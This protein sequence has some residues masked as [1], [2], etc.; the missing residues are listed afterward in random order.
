MIFFVSLFFYKTFF[1]SFLFLQL[2]PHPQIR[3]C[4]QPTSAAPK[5][6]QKCPTMKTELKKCPQKM[7]TERKICPKI[8]RATPARTQVL[9]LEVLRKR[10]LRFV[11]PIFRAPKCRTVL[12]F[13][14]ISSPSRDRITKPTWRRFL[15]KHQCQL[16][17]RGNI[18]IY[19]K[20]LKQFNKSF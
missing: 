2:L 8:L 20:H 9:P 5:D 16:P 14:S 15:I 1:C 6:R 4:Q 17:S 12:A 7:K 3:L 19:L 11:R 18:L 10:F 13:P